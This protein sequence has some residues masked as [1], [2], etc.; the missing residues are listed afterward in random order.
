MF[1]ALGWKI[2]WTP[3]YCPKFQPIELVRGVGKQRASSL[4]FPGRTLEQ[5]QLDLRKGFGCDTD[6]APNGRVDRGAS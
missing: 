1:S 3:P 2:I 6:R 4:Y 5:T